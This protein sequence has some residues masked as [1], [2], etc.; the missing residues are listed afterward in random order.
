MVGMQRQMMAMQAMIIELQERNER[1]E[2]TIK[3]LTLRLE[4]NDN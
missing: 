2:E 1:N 4:E 3:K